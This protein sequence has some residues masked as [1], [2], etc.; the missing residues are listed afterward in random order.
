MGMVNGHSW[1]QYIKSII[2][3][4]A[5]CFAFTVLYF[6]FPTQALAHEHIGVPTF[7]V[8]AGFESHYR[9][10]NWVP[11][12]VTLHNDG[13]D[14]NGTLSLITPTP[15]F[16]ASSN[17]GIPS[18]YQVSINL[19]NGAQKQVTMYLPLYFDVQNVTVNLLD[20]SGNIVGSQTAALTPLMPGDVLIGILSD[21]STGFGSL[22]TVPLPN[23]GGSVVL[24][25]LNANTTTNLSAMQLSALQNWVKRGGSL[26]L[27]GGPEWHRTLGTLPAGLVPIKL[28]GSTTIPAGT[29]LLPPGGPSA[30]QPGQN[31]IPVTLQAPVSMK[32]FS[33]PTHHL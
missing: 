12:Q 32:S 3:L 6:V 18:N 1:Q 28:S 23:Q 24:E 22:S 29:V 11:V 9:D 21:Q 5:S 33:L 4:A 2:A 13:P 16:Q 17:Q 8:N 20:S 7:Q 10:G 26:I 30:L 31:S 25:F 15:Q 14:F 27:V 19:A